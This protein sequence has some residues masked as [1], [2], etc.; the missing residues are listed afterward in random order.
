MTP[1]RSATALTAPVE[2]YLKAIYEI[3]RSGSAAGTK[4]IAG[5]LRIAPPC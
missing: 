2:D 3:E 5:A 1:L 4:E